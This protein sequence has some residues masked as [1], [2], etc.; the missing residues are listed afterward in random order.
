MLTKYGFK[1]GAKDT[2]GNEQTLNDF[3]TLVLEN[4]KLVVY[5]ETSNLLKGNQIFYCCEF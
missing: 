5:A 1:A 3:V 2:E 4:G